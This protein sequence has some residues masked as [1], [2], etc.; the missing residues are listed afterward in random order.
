[1]LERA[2]HA[3]MHTRIQLADERFYAPQAAPPFRVLNVSLPFRFKPLVGELASR[4]SEMVG[5]P[6]GAVACTAL[7]TPVVRS[8][9]HDRFIQFAIGVP[10]SHTPCTALVRALSAPRTTEVAACVPQACSASTTRRCASPT[11]RAT[12]R[13]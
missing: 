8:G 12:R 4:A 5:C 6:R 3:C 9:F 10:Q 11:A 7:A 1:M 2:P 13:A